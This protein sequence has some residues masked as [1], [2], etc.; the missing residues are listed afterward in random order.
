MRVT[1]F[2]VLVFPKILRTYL[3]DDPLPNLVYFV[4]GTCLV[5]VFIYPIANQLQ[6][7][8]QPF[9]IFLILSMQLY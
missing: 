2:D 4:V 3:T 9:S 7:F 5:K 1:G 6:H 8:P